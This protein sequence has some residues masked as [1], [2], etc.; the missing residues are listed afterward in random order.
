MP[1]ARPGAPARHSAYGTVDELRDLV[2]ALHRAGLELFLDVVFNHTGEGDAGGPTSSLRGLGNEAYYMLSPDDPGILLAFT[3]CGNTI[4]ANDP[5]TSKLVYDCL[6]YWVDELHVDGFRDLASV[7]ARG[8][9]GAV[10]S[11]RP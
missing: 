1:S 9:D 8:P 3:G 4:D 6:A 11:T 7:L 5:I 2:K 10:M